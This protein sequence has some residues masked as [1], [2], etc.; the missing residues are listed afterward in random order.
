ME[1]IPEGYREN[2]RGDLIPEKNVKVVNLL[3][4]DVIQNCMTKML[5]LKKRMTLVKAEVMQEISDFISLSMAEYGAKYGG[6]GNVN[7]TSFDGKYRIA[8]SVSERR[9]FDERIQAAEQLIKDCIQSWGQGADDRLMAVV[10]SA[11]NTDK[12]GNIDVNRVLGLRQLDI[13]DTAWINAM[14][15]I[16]DAIQVTGSKQ[17]FR[18]YQ[19]VES[20]PK[21]GKYENIQLD[22]STI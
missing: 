13:E 15:A 6:K 8:I 17:H 18:I 1:S 4:D 14:N 16:S 5:D 20:G 19:R 21:K 12:Q 22:I 11:F 3:R 7:L 2:A 9:V 10:G